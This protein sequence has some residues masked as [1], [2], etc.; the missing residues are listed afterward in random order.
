M[1]VVRKDGK[2]VSHHD[3]E[4]QA[5]MKLQ[6]IQPMSSDY[7]FRYG[8]YVIKEETAVSICLL[9]QKAHLEEAQ[10]QTIK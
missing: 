6:E 7:A 5:L 8:G 9:C 1:F 4:I 10:C 3:T 2:Y